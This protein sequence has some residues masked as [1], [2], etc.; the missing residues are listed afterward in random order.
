MTDAGKT[1]STLAFR[2][3]SMTLPVGRRSCADCAPL[4]ICRRTG[5]EGGAKL[6]L[7]IKKLVV[8]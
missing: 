8:F 1:S 3:S 7:F 2:G 5:T 6:A 4:M